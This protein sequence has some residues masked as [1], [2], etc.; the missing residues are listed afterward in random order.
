MYT[1]SPNQDVT[2]SSVQ[3]VAPID[4]VIPSQE[5]AFSSTLPLSWL[6]LTMVFVAVLY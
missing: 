5:V 1:V 4:Q 3:V 6:I 2:V